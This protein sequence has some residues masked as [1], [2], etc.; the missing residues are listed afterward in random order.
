MIAISWSGIREANGFSG[1][2]D[3]LSTGFSSC[4]DPESLRRILTVPVHTAFTTGHTVFYGHH[5]SE[6]LDA[7][8]ERRRSQVGTCRN[9][10]TLP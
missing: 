5:G 3:I 9:L 4:R 7:Y 8:V 10:N 1:C 6:I 2:V